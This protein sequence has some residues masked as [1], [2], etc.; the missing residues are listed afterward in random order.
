M[1]IK[2]KFIHAFLAQAFVSTLIVWLSA[3]VQDEVYKDQFKIFFYLFYLNLIPW[4]IGYLIILVLRR[5]ARWNLKWISRL[6]SVI[7]ISF[8]WFDFN[9]TPMELLFLVISNLLIFEVAL[10]RWRIKGIS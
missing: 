4:G 1:T 2:I 7:I 3:I 5:Y 8:I 9:L 6:L 10:F